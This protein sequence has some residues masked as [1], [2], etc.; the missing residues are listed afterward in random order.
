M[1]MPIGP[2][3]IAAV[4]IGFLGVMLVLGPEAL[5]GASLAALLPMLAGAMYAVGNIAT[6]EWCAEESAETLLAGFFAGLGILGLVGMAALAVWPQ[7]A[8]EGPEGFLLR[9]PVFWPPAAFWIWTFVQAAGSLLGVGLMIRSYQ[10]ADAGPRLGAGIH[11]PAGLGLLVLG[12]LVRDA[13]PGRLGRHGTDRGG[14]PDDCRPRPPASPGL[15]ARPGTPP[16][17]R[18]KLGHQDL[19]PG[20]LSPKASRQWRRHRLW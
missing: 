10:I 12:D 6:R 2:V 5:A 15:T 1:A 4:A 3:R 18:R 20:H 17:F 8:P 9:G 13:G 7:V 14:G 19:W 16:S 11:H